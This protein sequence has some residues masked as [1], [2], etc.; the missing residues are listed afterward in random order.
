MPRHD[1]VGADQA[2]TRADQALDKRS[3]DPERWVR[4]HLEGSARQTEIGPVGVYDRHVA[5]IETIPQIPDTMR[6]QL[7][8]DDA[9]AGRDER[10]GYGAGSGTNVE[11]KVSRNDAGVRDDPARPTAIELMPPPPWPAG[12]GHDGPSPCSKS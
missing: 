10:P 5:S 12:G 11:N 6:M 7:N 2:A 9:R 4:H 1:Q 3:G 8:G